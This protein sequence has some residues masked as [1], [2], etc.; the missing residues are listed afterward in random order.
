MQN[1]DIQIPV[2]PGELIDKITVLEIKR[3]RLTDESKRGHVLHELA[4]LQ[5]VL[6]SLPHPEGIDELHQRLRAANETIWESEDAIRQYWEDEARF[7]EQSRIS[8]ATNDE[9]FRIKR[10][11]NE[12][13]GSTIIEVKSHQK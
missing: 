8:H 10:E 1:S 2:S 6:E 5:K 11:I 4:L 13:F 7:L 9:R 12:L 3:D